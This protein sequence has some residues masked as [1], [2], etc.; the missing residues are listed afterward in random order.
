VAYKEMGLL[1][2]AVVEFIMTTEDEPMFIHSRYMLG[3]CYMEKGRVSNAICEIQMHWITL[4][5]WGL[6]PRIE[7]LCA[8]TSDLHFK[9]PEISTPP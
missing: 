4:R 3:L 7:S 6:T 8:T 1:D 9:A 2:N 5:Q